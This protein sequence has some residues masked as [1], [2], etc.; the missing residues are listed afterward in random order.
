MKRKIFYSSLFGNS[1]HTSPVALVNRR[2]GLTSADT[3]GYNL[4]YF[5]M[6]ERF[7]PGHASGLPVVL[8]R[9]RNATE[10]GFFPISPEFPK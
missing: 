10:G 3:D 2:K 9:R 1:C 5:V 4:S 8:D 6:T 7:S